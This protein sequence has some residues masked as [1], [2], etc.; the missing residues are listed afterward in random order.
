MALER[1]RHEEVQELVRDSDIFQLD[2]DNDARWV[3][4][5]GDGETGWKDID[6]P[7]QDRPAVQPGTPK[8][9]HNPNRA[10][11]TLCDHAFNKLDAQADPRSNKLARYIF[12]DIPENFDYTDVHLN[13]RPIDFITSTFTALLLHELRCF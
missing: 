13:S 11:I 5:T 7:G 1:M 2:C 12:S 4:K 8:T 3:Q 6:Y 10:T 9:N